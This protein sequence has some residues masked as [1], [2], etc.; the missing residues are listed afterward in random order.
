M[1]GS[2]ETIATLGRR[3]RAGVEAAEW[4]GPLRHY[5]II[6]EAFIAL[7]VVTLLTVG[8]AI[9]FSSPD[10]AP[11]TLQQWARAQPTGFTATAL[12]ELTGTS[13]SATYGPPYNHATGATQRIGPVSP[14][15]FFGVRYP[16]DPAASFVLRPLESLPRT[17]ALAHALS[18]YLSASA[19]TRIAWENAYA[20]RLAG[21]ALSAGL[22][23]VR[24]SSAGP[25]PVLLSNLLSMARS[26]ALDAQLLAH[27]NFYTTNY[28]KPLMFLGDSWKAQH[29]RSYWGQIVVAAHLRSSQW[30]VMNETG[31]WP[32]QPWLWL[33]TMWYQVPPAS[34]TP[35][36]ADIYVM[37][38]MAVV[39]L[40]LVAVPFLPGLR[41][42]PRWIPVHRVIWRQYYR[43]RI[44]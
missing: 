21:R 1:S 27:A 25:I 6:K 35:Q 20:S 43:S 28:T 30:G 32:G 24:S 19:A 38:F 9:L 3:V 34:S 22:P 31:S 41:D 18:R 12:S 10:Q 13:D 11:V 2:G 7:V 40:G 37:A 44:D 26:G 5:D 39:S 4:R 16:I 23:K 36:N 14:Q 8:L 15:Q 42:V 33:Y 17:P 29:A